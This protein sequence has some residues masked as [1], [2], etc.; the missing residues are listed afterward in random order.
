MLITQNVCLLFSRNSSL[1]NGD[2]G[3]HSEI[4][5]RRTETHTDGCPQ[6]WFRQ[7]ETRMEELLLEKYQLYF[8]LW[9]FTLLMTVRVAF[10]LMRDPENYWLLLT[11]YWELTLFLM[12]F[13]AEVDMCS[14]I[15]LYN[16]EFQ[17]LEADCCELLTPWRLLHFC[18]KLWLVN[19]TTLVFGEPI[20]YK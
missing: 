6:V 15:L 7:D 18:Q 20:L 11:I 8:W 9:S 10:I 13:V 4:W 1:F 3:L 16:M 5:L 2:N 12:M 14:F 17:D 19:F